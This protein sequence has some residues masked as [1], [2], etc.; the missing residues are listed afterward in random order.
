[1]KHTPLI[2]LASI[3]IFFACTNEPKNSHLGNWD[4]RVIEYYDSTS[5]EWEI[6]DW[7]KGGSG[8]LTYL[9]DS[10][11]EVEF[12]PKTYALDSTGRYASTASYTHKINSNLFKHTRLTHTDKSENGQTVERYITVENDTLTMSAK[13]FGLRLVWQ[14]L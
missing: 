14:R 7:M 4:L 3:L 2:T 11:M 8:K 12:L 10:M 6:S 1:M 5:N 13:E 9:N